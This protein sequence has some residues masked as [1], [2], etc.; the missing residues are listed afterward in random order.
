MLFYS[1]HKGLKVSTKIYFIY[2]KPLSFSGQSA[3]T[4][5]IIEKLGERGWD[6]RRVPIY[7]LDRGLRNQLLRYGMFGLRLLGSW[8]HI[9]SLVFSRRPVVNLNLGQSMGSFIRVGVPYFIT[10]II[11]A[12][13]RVVVS[14]HGSVF[15][16]WEKGSLLNRAFMLFLKSA[17]YTT[18]LGVKQQARLVELGLPEDRTR[19]VPNTCELDL[20]DESS[21]KSKQNADSPVKLLH[22]SLLI[23]SKGY[24]LYL[25]ALELLAHERPPM[26]IEA[27]LCGPLSYTAYCKRFTNDADKSSWIE[28]KLDAINR[29]S[30]GMVKVKWIRGAQG[31]D[32][33]QLF[34]DAQIFVFPS[35]FP[36]EA[37]PLVLL[38]AMASG[39]ALITS[40]VGEIP[41]TVNSSCACLLESVTADEVAQ[42][43]RDL[44]G[45]GQRR[46]TMASAGLS[47]LRGPFSPETYGDTWEALLTGC[48]Q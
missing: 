45:D 30:A 41:S 1:L 28:E 44:V 6:C 23:E 24:P 17:Q 14:L 40:T 25:E 8:L 34:R 12:D 43:I 4:D 5:L 46:V 48:Q 29:R 18:V 22:L 38:E 2:I 33:A 42:A 35:Q 31:V 36:V 20:M 9:F 3:A 37:Q 13:M 10:R 27:I 7:S 21:V 32:K 19:V 39:C 26:P 16:G 15:M 47:R 11:R